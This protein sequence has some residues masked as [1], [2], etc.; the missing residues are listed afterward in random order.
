[1]KNKKI[2]KSKKEIS[3]N[4]NYEEQ[5]LEIWEH[6]RKSLQTQI[7][8]WNLNAK[9]TSLRFKKFKSLQ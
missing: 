8:A 9:F 1:M 7:W 2:M 3:Q 4:S 6:L 5:D